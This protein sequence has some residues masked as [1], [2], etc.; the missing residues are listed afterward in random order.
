PPPPPVYCT[1]FAQL[2]TQAGSTNEIVNLQLDY[3]VHFSTPGNGR[4]ELRISLSLDPSSNSGTEDLIGIAVKDVHQPAPADLEVRNITTG[5]LP[6][7][8][9]PLSSTQPVS[10]I[11]YGQ[12]DQRTDLP[13]GELKITGWGGLPTPYDMVVT[14]N[15]QGSNDGIVQS[16]QFVLSSETTDLDGILLNG[17]SWFI[18]LQSTDGGG[19]SAKTIGTLDGISPCIILP[20]SP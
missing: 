18:R 17:T 11:A 1:S 12:I 4:N 15:L 5:T 9:N 6:Q 7:A 20:P 10:L 19:G 8:T 14:T 13:G 3:G 16:V 2:A